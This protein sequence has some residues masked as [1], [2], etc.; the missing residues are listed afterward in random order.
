MLAAFYVRILSVFGV[1][2][3]GW[4]W[5]MVA[6]LLGLLIWLLVGSFV[7]SP[8]IVYNCW[9]RLFI[10]CASFLWRV[11]LLWSCWRLLSFLS[12]VVCLC[13]LWFCAG[14][15]TFVF[16]GFW[17]RFCSWLDICLS[18]CN[19]LLWCPLLAWCEIVFCTS[20]APWRHFSQLVL[21]S[22]LWWLFPVC[23]CV[24]WLYL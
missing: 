16:L 10:G 19:M 23:T 5:L 6:T 12:W 24:C 2:L 17:C 3:E 1:F 9:L 7:G 14:V 22:G 4:T 21:G 15:L 18:N 13:W 8:V 20:V 11:G